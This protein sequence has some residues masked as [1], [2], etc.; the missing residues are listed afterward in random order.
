[1]SSR[2]VI[3]T[4]P[5]GNPLDRYRAPDE[6]EISAAIERLCS[7]R[8]FVERVAIEL[9]EEAPFIEDVAAPVFFY[10]QP[11]HEKQRYYDQV[12]EYVTANDLDYCDDIY[13]EI[14]RTRCE[15]AAGE[16][17]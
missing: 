13:E 17:E 3:R 5:T 16:C 11:D 1:M 15:Q 6:A 4:G 9:W 14:E 10:Q 7:R 2:A 8:P 12:H